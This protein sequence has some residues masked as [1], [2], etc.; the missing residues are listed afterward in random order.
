MGEAIKEGFGGEDEK[1]KNDELITEVIDNIRAS[2]MTKGQIEIHIFDLF[3]KKIINELQASEIQ[4]RL[5][6][7]GLWEPNARK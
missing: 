6:E 1:L 5:I 2:N 4:S 7:E 3:R